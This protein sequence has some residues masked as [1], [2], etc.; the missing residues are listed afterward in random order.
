MDK[1]QEAGPAKLLTPVR[2]W[3]FGF[4]LIFSVHISW[5]SA[6]NLPPSWDMAHHQLIGLQMAD[7][8]AS[9]NLW[10]GYAGLS[11]YYPPLYYLNEALVIHLMGDSPILPLLSNLLGLLLLSYFTFRAGE[12]FLPQ[13]A[14]VSAGLI[15]LTL[16]MIAWTSRV[17]LLDTGLAGWVILA[18]YLL[19]KSDRFENRKLTLMFG[20]AAALGML[21]KWTFPFFLFLPVIVSL[22]ASKS[23]K[24]S[25]LNILLA[26]SIAMVLSATWYWPNAGEL[27]E[28]FRSTAEAGTEFERDPGLAS[29]WGWVYYIRCLASY[30]L[31]LPL[32]LLLAASLFRLRKRII[33]DYALLLIGAGLLGSLVSMTMLDMK[34]PRYIMPAAPFAVLLLIAGWINRPAVSLIL[35]PAWCFLQLIL[36][37]FSVPGIPEKI[38][39]FE[40]ENDASYKSMNYE[41]VLFETSYFDILGKARDEYWRLEEILGYFQNGEKVAVIPEHPYFNTTTL[42]L[43]A[44]RKG[45]SGIEFSRVGMEPFERGQFS[46]ADWA[47]GKSG[48]QGVD[49]LTLF[50]REAYKKLRDNQWP[51]EAILS[52]PDGSRARIWDLSAAVQAGD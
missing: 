27:L 39:F 22:A 5:E 42:A 18:F 49:F 37:S 14:A 31:F 33:Q 52:L 43:L 4:L 19:L 16:P 25:L 1:A 41:L 32:T 36:V 29:I 47:I 10:E 8:L 9:G 2:I 48:D 38:A 3:A 28:R 24:K 26:G 21:H 6:N 13:P 30:Y 20:A 35:I 12:L 51:I 15:I 40:V 11:N 45:L 46:G 34:D 17:S 50:N 44:Y 7:A 23:K